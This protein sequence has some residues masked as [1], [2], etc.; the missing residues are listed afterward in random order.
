M[1]P[2]TETCEVECLSLKEIIARHKQVFPGPYFLD[3]DVEGF[4]LQVLNTYDFKEN[5]PVLVA[6]E[7]TSELSTSPI[8]LYLQGAKY[9][10]IGRTII[11]SL[12]ID[13]TQDLA[14]VLNSS[15]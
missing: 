15:H 3:I 13:L 8:H 4:D 2:V 9:E 11:T 12:Y 7:D 6:I 1:S 5:R 10:L 14:R